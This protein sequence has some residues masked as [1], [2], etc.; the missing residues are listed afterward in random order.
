M[1]CSHLYRRDVFLNA[2][3]SIFNTR[4]K[5][6]QDESNLSLLCCNLRGIEREALRVT[7]TGE[8]SQ[9]P[10]PGALGSALTHPSITTDYSEAL[11]EFITEPF[12]EIGQVLDQLSDVHSFTARNLPKNEYLWPTSM[13]CVLGDDQEIPIAQYGSSNVGMMKTIYRRGLGH[14]YGRKMQTIAGIH[15]NFS[16]PDAVWCQMR[17]ADNSLLALQDYRTQGYMGLVRNFRRRFW[18][19]LYL[20]GASPVADKS[21]VQ[22]RV[23][24]LQALNDKDLYLPHATSLRMGDLGYQS[25]AQ[26][27]LYVCYNSTESYVESLKNA[28]LKEYPAYDNLVADCDDSMQSQQLSSAVLQIENEFYSTIRPKQTTR[29]GETQLKALKERGIEYIEVRCVDINPYEPLGI[30]SEQIDF[31][32][33]FLLGCLFDHSPGTTEEEY[34]EVLQNQRSV[35]RSGREKGLTLLRDGQSIGM[36]DWALEVMEQLEPIAGVLDG[37]CSRDRYTKVLE[38]MKTLLAD[39][40]KTPSARLLNDLQSSNS[41]FIDWSLEQAKKHH[42][43]LTESNF[44]SPTWTHFQQMADRSLSDQKA[45]EESQTDS[46][47]DYIE[48]YFQQYRNL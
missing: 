21:F 44:D 33:L 10:H 37:L 12:P 23:H 28:L 5:L 17:A 3:N 11:L 14:R 38:Q 8:I 31:L 43:M 36:H 27:D 18:L 30:N 35:V 41:C 1:A 6:F 32:E 47:C 20:M 40:D 45:I 34:R 42:R 26:D 15:F 25:S 39:P 2:N 19:L 9:E 46:L 13:P 16:V 4:L 29:T 24:D 48:G 7:P 22:G